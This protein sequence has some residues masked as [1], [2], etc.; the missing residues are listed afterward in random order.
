LEDDLPAKED[1]I[2]PRYNTKSRDK[3]TIHRVVQIAPKIR[4]SVVHGILFTQ[5]EGLPIGCKMPEIPRLRLC[6][7]IL[8]QREMLWK[9]WCN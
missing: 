2:I 1:D 5:S 8:L 3:P 9:I 4:K 6:G 7:Q